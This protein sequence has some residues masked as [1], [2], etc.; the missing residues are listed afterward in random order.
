RVPQ[1]ELSIFCLA[2]CFWGGG[3]SVATIANLVVRI[4]A[5]ISNFEQNMTQMQR[6]MRTVG[7]KLTSVGK[8]MTASVTAPLA[9]LGIAAVA[10]GAKFDEQMSKVKAITGATGK[11]FDA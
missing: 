10:T 1:T 6:S 5:D 11:E 4:G 7:D 9:G 3:G 2:L 8:T